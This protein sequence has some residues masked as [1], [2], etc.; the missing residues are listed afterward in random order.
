MAVKS[1]KQWIANSLKI[2]N[3]FV[4]GAAKKIKKNLAKAFYLL[5]LS[6]FR[7]TFQKGDLVAV[8]DSKKRLRLRVV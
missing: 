4:D 3:I 5:E 2:K 8:C 1:K 7:V 6:L